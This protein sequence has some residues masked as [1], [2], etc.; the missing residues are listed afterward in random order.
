MYYLGNVSID[1]ARMLLSPIGLLEKTDICSHALSTLRQSRVRRVVMVGRRG[2]LQ[3]SFTTKELRELLKLEQTTALLAAEDHEELASIIP[4]LPRGRKR[5]IELLYNTSKQ[6]VDTIYGNRELEIKY[7]RSPTQINTDRDG[8]LSS[9]T[10]ELNKL[11]KPNLL[12][13]KAEATG[14][15]DSIQ[16]GI[17]FR[18]I[19]Y[20]SV[21]IVEGVP[22]D[23]RRNVVPN[24]RGRVA[25]SDGELF[26]GLYCSGWIKRGAVGV[27]ASTMND[28]F[29]TADSI[30]EDISNGN[31]RS[32][33]TEFDL[34][35]VL[36]DG[37]KVVKSSHWS[38]LDS[39]EVSR[40]RGSKPREKIVSVSEMIDMVDCSEK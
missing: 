17:A 24:T 39:E 5:L 40:G 38:S 7:L 36:P 20:K 25:Y 26:T 19:G 28:A 9:I 22:F 32:V 33:N 6:T 29:E 18:S 34:S 30:A 12:E 15:H 14:V 16:C 2:P 31:L 11:E 21:P 23:E 4:S 8:K 27:I 3:V 35:S 1:V 13:S 10:F 37:H